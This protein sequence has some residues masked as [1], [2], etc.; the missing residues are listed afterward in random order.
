[1]KQK[2]EEWVGETDNSSVVAG[3]FNASAFHRDRTTR[4]INKEMEKL[5]NA[6][7]AAAAKSLQSCPTLRKT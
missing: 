4:Q 6:A 5:N 2:L 3:D 7:A 1:M